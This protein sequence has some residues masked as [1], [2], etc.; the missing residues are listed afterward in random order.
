PR[1]TEARMKPR[2]TLLL[3]LAGCAGTGDDLPA[4]HRYNRARA[5]FHAEDWRAATEAA[6]SAAALGDPSVAAHCDFLLGSIAFKRCELAERQASTPE[7]E[8]FAFDVAIRYCDTAREAWERAAM[9]RDDW[10]AARRN[11][12]RA[13][14]N[15]DELA[16]KKAEAERRRDRPPRPK[17]QP[18]PQ[19]GEGEDRRKPDQPPRE[20]PAIAELSREEVLRL[21]DKLQR[22]EEEKRTVRTERRRAESSGV[23]RDW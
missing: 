22:K 3:L 4:P 23:E 19:P 8:P 1:G 12:E 15:R 16:R 10:P 20:D 18:K 7:A 13:L 21:F 9:G 17:P 14:L 11:V 5:A 2:L 6:T